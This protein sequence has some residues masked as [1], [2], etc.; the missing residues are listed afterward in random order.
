VRNVQG[1]QG[2]GKGGLACNKQIKGSK[3]K[4]RGLLEQDVVT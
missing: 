3:D 1:R 2:E 4:I